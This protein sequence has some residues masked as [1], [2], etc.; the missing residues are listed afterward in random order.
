MFDNAGFESGNTNHW[1]GPTGLL[2][3][4][5]V[6]GHGVTPSNGVYY[7][8][9]YTDNSGGDVL[10]RSDQYWEK[11]AAGYQYLAFDYRVLLQGV[12][13]TFSYQ[14]VAQTSTLTG[15]YSNSQIGNG[16]T[17]WR[18]VAFYV[19]DISTSTGIKINFL[20]DYT[21]VFVPYSDH[22]HYYYDYGRWTSDA[23]SFIPGYT[24]V[25]PLQ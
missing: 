1:S 6:D 14:I 15:T 24:I 17:G 25:S 7:G 9:S 12:T 8:K 18:T 2:Q 4:Q 11:P 16:D 10:V 19:G 13:G 5:S 21:G 3:V 20:G 23:N 22:V